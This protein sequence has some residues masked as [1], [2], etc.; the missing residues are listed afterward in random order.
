MWNRPLRARRRLNSPAASI[1]L[2][3]VS[4]WLPPVGARPTRGDLMAWFV[5]AQ[6]FLFPCLAVTVDHG[7][8]GIYGVL[9]VLALVFGW[10]GWGRLHAWEK[11]VL[12]GFISFAG[13]VGLSMLIASRDLGEAADGYSKHL[14][15]AAFAPMYL[16]LRRFDLN[17]SRPLIAGALVGV[18][19]M[20]AQAVYQHYALGIERPGGSR[21]P[22]QFSDVLMLC[23]MLVA[24][25]AVTRFKRPW[26]HLAAVSAIAAG[27]FGGYVSLT[28]NAWL[29]VPVVLV[30]LV[31]YYRKRMAK[32]GWLLLAG[33]LAVC[34]TIAIHPDSLV[35]REFQSGFNDI[36][37]FMEDPSQTTSWGI[38]LNM[39]RNAWIIFKESPWFGVGPGDYEQAARA[40]VASGVSYSRDPLIYEQAHNAYIH[41]MAESGI[42]TMLAFAIG[43]QLMPLLAFASHWRTSREDGYSFE[44]LGGLT[45]VL[46]FAIYGIGHAWMGSNNFN[47][48]YLLFML[49]FLSSTVSAVNAAAAARRW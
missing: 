16:M 17:L 47:S 30:L 31:A 1:R 3:S 48:I 29:L 36:Q 8:T 23:T 42:F 35:H 9:F 28:R 22:V 44:V 45:V 33:S 20:C 18:F 43:V 46:A 24:L 5:G 13:L 32:P 49:V 21:D 12:I 11:R 14:R 19:V 37:L 41:T 38:R 26:Q 10:R 6:V 7:A 34:S 39:W 4:A 25:A 27:L 2:Q 15:F 40:L